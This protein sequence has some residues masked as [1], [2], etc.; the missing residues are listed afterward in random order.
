MLLDPNNHSWRKKDKKVTYVNPAY[1]NLQEKVMGK[2]QV[3]YIN[4]TKQI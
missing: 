2:K 4:A 3:T 1:E